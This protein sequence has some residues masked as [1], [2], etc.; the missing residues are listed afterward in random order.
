MVGFSVRCLDQL[1]N[2]SIQRVSKN[3][4]P[5]R[6]VWNPSCYHYTK[7]AYFVVPSERVELPIIRFVFRGFSIKLRRYKQFRSTTRIPPP[8]FMCLSLVRCEL[9]CVY[10]GGRTHGLLNHNQALYQLSYIHHIAE[11][12]GIEPNARR[13]ISLSRRTLSPS[14]FIFRSAH[15][16][17]RTY[18]L[19]R[20][21]SALSPIELYERL[22]TGKDSNLQ[23]LD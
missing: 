8:C 11:D 16:R 14:R 21:R 3:S 7:D 23:P 10:D 22:R 12:I 15:N 4:N 9:F 17:T 18:N 1:G 5:D 20:I 13:H 19:R 6:W 2:C